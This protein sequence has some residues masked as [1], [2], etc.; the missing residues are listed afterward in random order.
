L[1]GGLHYLVLAGEASW[2]AVDSTL[3]EHGDFLRRFVREHGVQTNEV[4][5]SWVLLPSFLFA[6]EQGEADVLDLVELGSSAGLNLLWDR[7]GYTYAEGTWG[8]ADARLALA[9]EER[10]SVPSRLLERVPRVRSRL[11][12]DRE[13]LDVRGHEAARLLKAFVWADQRRRLERIEQAIDT[14]R[15]DPPQLCRADVVEVLP[16]LLASRRSDALTLV[17]ET[18][19]FGYLTSE[20]R[21]RA[22]SALDHAG[23]QGG[24]AFVSTGRAR[25]G[26]SAWGLRVTVWPDGARTYVAHADYHG[27]WLDWLG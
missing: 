4:Q 22:R 11:G 25:S 18:A 21:A 17:F 2:D 26:D 27:A 10:G 23:R 12:I 1:L 5:R 19:T 8:P 24:L 7:Y 16:D 9:G 3:D 14:V 13:P 20:E 15:D 6:A